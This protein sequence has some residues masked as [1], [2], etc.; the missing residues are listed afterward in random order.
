MHASKHANASF[1]NKINH[2]K[3]PNDSSILNISDID[4]ECQFDFLGE[5]Y[6]E[7]QGQ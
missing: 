6:P 5:N 7:V 1:N 3:E 2:N 4:S